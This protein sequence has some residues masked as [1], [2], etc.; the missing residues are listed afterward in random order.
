M[1]EKVHNFGE[2]GFIL[3][4]VVGVAEAAALGAATAIKHETAK[5]TISS[6]KQTQYSLLKTLEEAKRKEIE[7]KEQLL[8]PKTTLEWIRD[9]GIRKLVILGGVT[10]VTLAALGMGVLYWTSK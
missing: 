5:K 4:T 7:T 3:A 8:V 2:F 10:A 1:Y 9:L 6:S